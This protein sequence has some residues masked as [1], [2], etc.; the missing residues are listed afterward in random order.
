MLERKLGGAPAAA[1][2]MML[3]WTL[4]PSRNSLSSRR[5]LFVDDL[6]EVTIWAVWKRSA[7]L[8]WLLRQMSPDWCM[9]LLYFRIHGRKIFLSMA[10]N[11]TFLYRLHRNL[12]ICLACFLNL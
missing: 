7:Y 1:W 6:E 2:L 11:S 12:F 3:P 4:R 5:E 8:T 10:V 9:A